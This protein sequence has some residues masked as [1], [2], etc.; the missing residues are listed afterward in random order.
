E[1]SSTWQLSMALASFS[2]PCLRGDLLPD[3][4]QGCLTQADDAPAALLGNFP[5]GR[6]WVHRHRMRDALEQRQ[7]VARIAV[8]IGAFEA[9]SGFFQ[10]ALD[11][12]DLAFLEAW[13]VGQTAGVAPVLH[14]AF[15]GQQRINA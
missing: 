3:G 10:P 13:R 4:E 5:Q 6:V 7:V 12:R 14:L 2:C 15:G 11:A 1:H 8:E 9:M